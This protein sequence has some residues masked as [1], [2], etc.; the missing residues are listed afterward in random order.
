MAA[1]VWAV[2]CFG[3]QLML[4]LTGGPVRQP[5]GAHAA[6][7]VVRA[8]PSAE[9]ARIEIDSHLREQSD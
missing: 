5:V 1:D 2:L 8:T 7:S 9:S 3:P 6:H 4:E